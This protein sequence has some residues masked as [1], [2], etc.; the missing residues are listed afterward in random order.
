MNT[1]FFV[2]YCYYCQLNVYHVSINFHFFCYLKQLVDLKW[3]W[4]GS[5]NTELF[6]VFFVTPSTSE[7]LEECL[8]FR[9]HQCV[10]SKPSA[11]SR[12]SLTFNPSCSIRNEISTLKFSFRQSAN[13]TVNRFVNVSHLTSQ[14]F[15]AIGVP[16]CWSTDLFIFRW[17][18]QSPSCPF[19]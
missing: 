1:F 13:F 2:S 14:Q 10:E 12:D 16:S 17:K 6:G 8:S 9:L 19:D 15:R 5:D 18:I 7:Y 3:I 11:Y 4:S